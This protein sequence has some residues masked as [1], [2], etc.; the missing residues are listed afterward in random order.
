[1]GPII[2]HRMLL[3]CRHQY[4][5][6]LNTIRL[7]PWVDPMMLEKA[8]AMKAST[9]TVRT[10]RR[11]PRVARES[12]SVLATTPCGTRA[13]ESGATVT[14]DSGAGRACCPAAVHARAG[15]DGG[16]P[17]KWRGRGSRPAHVT[18]AWGGIPRLSLV[19]GAHPSGAKVLLRVGYGM[20]PS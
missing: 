13:H 19:E 20:V 2:A 18:E 7:L 4:S 9:I 16:A 11:M 10:A 17:A 5:I 14:S 3:L 12:R 8:S 1:M 15:S 6:L